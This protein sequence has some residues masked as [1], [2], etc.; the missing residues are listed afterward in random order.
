MIDI[1]K[2]KI[3]IMVDSCTD[4]PKEFVDK[5]EMFVVPLV[6][7]YSYGEFKDGVDITPDYVYE[8]FEKEIP[9]TSLPAGSE[10]I[11]VLDE[12]HQKGYEKVIVITIS[13]GLSG[14]HNL[15]RMMAEEYDKL[16]SIVIDTKSI[17]VGAGVSAILA[18][19]LL[20]KGLG[21]EEVAEKVLVAIKK[22]PLFFCLAT[23]E[24]LRKGGRMGLV[25]G[26][27]GSLLNILPVISCNEDGVYYTAKKSRGRK[28]SLNAAMDLLIENAK[29][30][31]NYKL[32]VVHG[33]AKEE[34]DEV[35]RK[36]KEALPDYSIVIEGQISPVLVVHTGPGLIGMGVQLV[37]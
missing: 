13:S 7:N 5:Y 9:T 32:V 34:A 19:E 21:F 17:G 35:L 12:I 4:V 20:E 1:N 24:Y 31:K 30:H 2:Q 25:S 23:L 11:K 15:L 26:A 33:G 29:G 16:E 6:I 10:I 3:A 8:N 18:G 14:T 36:L 37:D 22:T 27:V 28:S